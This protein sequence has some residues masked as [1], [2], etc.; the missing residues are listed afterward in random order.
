MTDL[1]ARE[2]DLNVSPADAWLALTDP[3]WL[4]MWLADEVSLDCVPGGEARFRFE[5]EVREGWVE[6][7]SPPGADQD[8]S[9]RLAFWWAHDDEPATRVELELE[10]IEGGRTRLRVAESRPLEILDLVGVPLPG[11]GRSGYGPALVAA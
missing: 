7:V 3:D 5:E 9:G 4:S 8:S 1:V 11:Y 2:L 10:P 6:E